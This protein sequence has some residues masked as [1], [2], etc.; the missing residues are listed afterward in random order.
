MGKNRATIAPV[1]APPVPPSPTTNAFDDYVS[2]SQAAKLLPSPRA[3]KRTHIS[4]L[5]RWVLS[6]K[7]PAVKRG[8]YYFVRVC[9]LEQ[10]SRPV[11][12]RRFA[13]SRGHERAMAE[14]RAAGLA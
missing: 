7:L 5:W 11:E 2:L 4:T 14:L 3:G 12:V 9:D 8:R 6:G 13:T 1:P 10:M